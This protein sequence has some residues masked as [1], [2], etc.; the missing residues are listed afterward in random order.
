[1]ASIRNIKKD[2]DYLVNEVVSDSFL[3]LQISTGKKNDEVIE[4]INQI[5]DK[6]ND[7]LSKINSAPKNNKETKAYFKAINKELIDS[8][9]NAFEK[10]S[11]VIEKK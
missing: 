9:D 8:V 5:A 6:R 7:L 3:C 4:V 1:M 2:I 10:L 11:K